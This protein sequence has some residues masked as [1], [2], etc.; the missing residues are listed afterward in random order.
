MLESD[1]VLVFYSEVKILFK[2]VIPLG[3]LK[4]SRSRMMAQ[5]FKDQNPNHISLNNVMHANQD[6]LMLIIRE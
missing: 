2:G 3:N 6:K 5:I 4:A 1:R